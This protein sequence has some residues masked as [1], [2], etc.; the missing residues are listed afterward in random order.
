M[1]RTLRGQLRASDLLGR[2]GG[3]EFSVFLPDTN[4]QGAL[5]VGETLRAAV[6]QCRVPTPQGVLEITASIGVA[7]RTEQVQTMQ[8]IQQQADE[9]M[10]EAKKAGRNRVCVLQG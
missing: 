3:E 6:A 10:Y 2:I 4:L 8:A 7:A 9:A 5:Q 1:A